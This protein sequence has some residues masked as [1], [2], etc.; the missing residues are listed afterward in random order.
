MKPCS[1]SGSGVTLVFTGSGSNYSTATISG[2]ATVNLTAPSTGPLAGIVIFGDR[3]TPQGTLYRF[4]GGTNQVFNG[5]VYLP[6]GQIQYSGGATG[7]NGCNQ[8]IGDT[9]NFVGNTNLAV[10]CTGVGT[11][12]VGA[13]AAKL[14]E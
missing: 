12:P 7:A 14:V 3:N 11:T 2:G 8:V 4:T 9:V 1:I 6:E 13:L 5:A 10:N